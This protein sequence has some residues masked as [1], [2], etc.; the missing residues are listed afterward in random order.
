MERIT[1]FADVILPLPVPGI[2]TYRIPFELNE[3]VKCGQRV[4]VQF[5]RKKIYT[6][7]IRKLHEQAPQHPPKYILSVLDKE[8][9]VNET[10]FGFW[11]W[12]ANYYMSTL[13]EVM[14]VALPQGLKLVSESRILLNPGFNPDDVVLNENE[15]HVTEALINRKKLSIT[16]ITKI[17]GLQKT[18]PL[19]KNMIDKGIIQIEEE[20]S[21]AYK[22]KLETFV[23]LH[24]DVR[25]D[26]Q[27]MRAVFEELNKRAF[28]QLQVLMA[29]LNLTL[30][31]DEKVTEVAQ[32]EL[33]KSVDAS[34]AQLKALEQKG[35]IRMYKKISS[36]LNF[37]K[38]TREI[39]SIELSED[40][41]K[42]LDEIQ[43]SFK[44]KDVALIHGVTSSGKTEIYIKLIEEAL[45]NGKQVLY[46]LPEIALTTQ[47]ISRLQKYFGEKIGVYHSRY[48]KNER[49]EIWNKVLDND[50]DST[51]YQ[52]ILGPRSALFLPYKNLGLIIVD[53]EHDNSYKQFDPS[54]R[55]NAR[56][57]AIYL[58]NLH[59]A[60][61]I[62]GSATPSVESYYNASHE[63]YALVEL[64]KRY[65][66]MQLPEIL[67]ADI[68]TETKR[69]SMHSHFSSFLLKHV[70]E[71]LENKE[72]VIL[73]QNRRG[74]SLRL[75]CETCDWIPE[76]VNCDVTLTYHKKSDHLR[77][78]Y[79]GYSTSVPSNCPNCNSTKILMRGFGTEKIEEELALIYPSANIERMDLDTTRSK[80]AYQRIINDFEN[81]KIDILVGTQMVTKGLD[82]D[83]VS[84]VGILNADNMLSYPDFRSPERSY[85][86]MA[87]VSGRAGRK[88]KRGKV[89]IQTYN[90][91]NSIIRD[92]IDN[93]Y[94][95]AYKDILL[96]RRNFNYPPFYRLVEIRLKY[97]EYNLLNEASDVLAQMLREKF[98]KRILGPEYP[99]VSRIKNQ[100]IKTIL[101][102][103]ERDK[104]LIKTKETLAEQVAAFKKLKSYKPVR[105]IIDV[106]PQ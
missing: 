35:I 96:D 103:I 45:Q 17:T 85:Q 89:I 64:N 40:Q 32:S 59:K 23:C 65:G 18:I 102:K 33:I 9:I 55:Y 10:Q 51:P 57:S 37:N 41:Q 67:V 79:C 21:D 100:F 58:A 80:N 93:N 6:A 14:N 38:A 104:S 94:I 16:D 52:I 62:L 70:E 88:H 95:K 15:Y 31:V 8:P 56:D 83:N 12:L 25:N 61:T 82:F 7:L 47:I 1:L 81:R 24:E 91:Y 5:G 22:P 73:F 69:K 72:Q 46:L 71:A 3:H 50:P 4:V 30:N 84:I 101:V 53:E 39:Q 13:G 43:Q 75:E 48:N 26:E 20:L 42:A 90:P 36:R 29:L 99:I 27:K 63:K 49:V 68:K 87:Q 34:H 74:F 97:K 76:C 86:L 105:I 44:E 78:H 19:I 2:F 77:C 92:V 98:G 106:D 60:K 66:G 28:K 11:E 54:P